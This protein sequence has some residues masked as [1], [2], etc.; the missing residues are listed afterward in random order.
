[1]IEKAQSPCPTSHSTPPAALASYT[2]ATDLVLTCSAG[3][4]H[5]QELF[6]LYNFIALVLCIL[7]HVS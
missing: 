3:R 1:M 4:T 6:E 2:L 5:L 7:D